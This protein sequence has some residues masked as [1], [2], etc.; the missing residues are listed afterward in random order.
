MKVGDESFVWEEVSARCKRL[1]IAIEGYDW[2]SQ[3]RFANRLGVTF[4]S[5]NN[6]EHGVPLS[7]MMAG[8]LF[9][10][11]PGLGGMDW[12]YYGQTGNLNS[13]MFE[14]LGEG[15]FVSNEDAGGENK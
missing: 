12:L 10:V 11:F 1:R 8:R 7:R 6:V 9:D 2:G 4:N 15:R 5:W 13:K 3:A 14:S